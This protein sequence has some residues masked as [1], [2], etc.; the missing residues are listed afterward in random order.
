MIEK[1]LIPRYI[2]V[3]DDCGWRG[4]RSVREECAERDLSHHK[5]GEHREVYDNM[6]GY[7]PGL[8]GIRYKCVCGESWVAHE[9]EKFKCPKDPLSA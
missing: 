5:C 1:K 7:R 6:G 8:P 4:E 2:P 9:Q 3:C